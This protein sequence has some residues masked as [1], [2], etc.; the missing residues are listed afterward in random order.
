M[1]IK[2]KSNWRTALILG[3]LNG[4]IYSLAQFWLLP[5]YYSWLALRNANLELYSTNSP[6]QMTN[7]LNGRVVTFWFVLQFAVSS[8]LIHRYF[9]RLIKYPILLWQVVGL[10]AVIGGNV[11]FLLLF[12]IEKELTGQTISYGMLTSQSNPLSGPISIGI[13]ILVNLVYGCVL[14]LMLQERG[15][16]DRHREQA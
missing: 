1:T 10:T 5:K 14:H 16:I 3:V 6:V 11:I 4:V 2:A 7:M 8:W 15:A 9:V 12:W 13:V